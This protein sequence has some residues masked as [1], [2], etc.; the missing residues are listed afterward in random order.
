MPPIN[1]LDYGL[2]NNTESKC[3]LTR[4]FSMLRMLLAQNVQVMIKVFV[5]KLI[6]QATAAPIFHGHEVY[7]YNTIQ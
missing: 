1:E 2:A 6:L 3:R 5:F 7:S 4:T